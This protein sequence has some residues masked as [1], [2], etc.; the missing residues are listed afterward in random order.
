[1]KDIVKKSLGEIKKDL[2]ERKVSSVEVTE[3]VLESIKN[4]SAA[5]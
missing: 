4:P 5:D 3:A 2:A 1:M